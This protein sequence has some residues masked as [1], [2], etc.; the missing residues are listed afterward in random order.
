M[1]YQSRFGRERWLRPALDER[2]E[3]WGRRGYRRVDV[4]CPGFA[5]DCLE[6]LEEVAVTSR[7]LFEKAGG[8]NFRYIP[9][10]NDR[11]EHIEALADIVSNHTRQWLQG[12]R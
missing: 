11:R 12:L 1:A 6:T 3:R 9:A 5:V 8:R 7:E 4:V 10:L 2:L